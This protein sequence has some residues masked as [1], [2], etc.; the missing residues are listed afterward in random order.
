MQRMFNLDKWERLRMGEALDFT[1]D[2]PRTVTIEVNAPE[3]TA[4]YVVQDG[5]EVFFLALVEGRDTL[6]FSSSGAFQLTVEGSDCMIYTAD[7]DDISMQA[8]DDVSFTKIVERRRRN[9]ELEAI[10]ATMSRNLE[11]RM[12][13]QAHEFATL[14]ARRAEAL[15]P[16]PAPPGVPPG[17]GGQPG[18]AAGPGPSGAPAAPASPGHTGSAAP[19]GQPAAQ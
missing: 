15:A 2:R 6:E 9:P 5:G 7:G 17:P 19:T 16:V 14:F 3:K 13:Q 10:A 18:Q 1:N 12:E 4:L 11:R 8:V